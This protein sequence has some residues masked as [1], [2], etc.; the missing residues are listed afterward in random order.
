MK[1]VAVFDEEE[2]FQEIW[3]FPEEKEENSYYLQYKYELWKRENKRGKLHEFMKELGAFL[4]EF[5]E[6]N[7]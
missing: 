5:E 3:V 4:C 6:L 1:L 2:V 7:K